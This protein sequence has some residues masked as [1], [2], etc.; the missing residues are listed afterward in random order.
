MPFTKTAQKSLLSRALLSGAAQT[1]AWLEGETSSEG[2]EGAKAIASEVEAFASENG[3]NL[4]EGLGK[5]IVALDG[6]ALLAFSSKFV[7]ALSEDL[8]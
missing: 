3:V 8:N 6:P 5:G 7:S 4:S 2:G 1:V